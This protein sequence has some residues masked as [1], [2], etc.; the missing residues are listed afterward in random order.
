VAT[1]AAITIQGLCHCA[2]GLSPVIRSLAATVRFFFIVSFCF[3]AFLRSM[4]L[5]YACGNDRS[6]VLPSVIRLTFVWLNTRSVRA[7]LWPFGC[8]TIA[9]TVINIYLRFST[10]FLPSSHL[11]FSLF[12]CY[13]HAI[14]LLLSFLRVLLVLFLRV[15]HLLLL[16]HFP[17]RLSPPSAP[18]PTRL[19]L[20]LL[21][22]PLVSVSL[23]RLCLCPCGARL[24]LYAGSS[25][26]EQP[27]P[28]PAVCQQ[29]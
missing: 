2:R 11:S 1:I 18:L 14:L 4:P 21:L 15:V 28:C 22:F 13:Y 3:S 12:C 29:C 24:H 17:T 27:M 26:Y 6:I 19:S 9:S 7:C 5:I 23:R 10:S 25:V 20:L 16:L 8:F